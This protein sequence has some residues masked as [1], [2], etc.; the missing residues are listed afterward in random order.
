MSIIDIRPRLENDTRIT[1]LAFSNRFTFQEE[2]AIESA[3][4]ND[5]AVRVILRKQTSATY[6]DLMDPLTAALLDELVSK[7]LITEARK[8]EI[9]NPTIRRIE[10]YTEQ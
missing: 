3:A 6:I 9:L 4:D 2:A 5:A 10:R 1:P 7:G 8:T